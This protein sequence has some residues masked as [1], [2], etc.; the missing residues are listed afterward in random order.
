MKTQEPYLSP[1]FP[2]SRSAFPFKHPLFLIVLLASTLLGARFAS[3]QYRAGLQGTVT[4]STGAVIPN[5][6]VTILDKETN[7][8]QTAKTDGA[9]TYTFNRLAPAS[10]TVTFEAPGFAK[11]I[12]DD[13]AISGETMQGLNVTLGAEGALLA[14]A[15]GVLRMPAMDVP[16]Q[17]SVGAGDAFLA[18]ATLTLAR[19]GTPMDALAWG[20]AAGAAVVACAGTARLRQSDVDARYRALCC[21]V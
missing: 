7:Q 10:Y 14:T 12:I 9:G 18:A 5:A 2:K 4:D 21:T 17:S 13:V 19:G 1:A 11:R 16:M 8:S 3:A 15:Q 6:S 20:T